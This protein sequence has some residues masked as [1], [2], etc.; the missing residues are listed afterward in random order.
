M[1]VIDRQDCNT[2]AQGLLYDKDTYRSL[3]KDLSAKCKSKLTNILTNCKAQGQ[4]SK[5]TYK[6]LYLTCVIPSKFYGFSKIHKPGI[7]P[8]G[9]YFP[10]GTQSCTE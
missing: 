2:K 5:T 7:P 10:V 4:I 3:C 1:V 6:R 9:P 8:S